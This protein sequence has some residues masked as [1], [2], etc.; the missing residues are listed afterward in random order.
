M[1]SI[2]KPTRLTALLRALGVACCTSLVAAGPGWA[3]S[4]SPWGGA[5]KWVGHPPSAALSADGG[6]FFDLPEI[7]A[8]LP[9]LLT[10]GKRAA[11]ESYLPA[12]SV[13]RVDH[14]LVVSRCQAGDCAAGTATLILDTA[15]RNIWFVLRVSTNEEVQHCWAGTAQYSGLPPALQAPFVD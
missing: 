9:R 4:S 2:F 13:Q 7:A 12:G 5:E 15:S 6:S 1:I 14:F 11:F 10:P 8:Q 3:A